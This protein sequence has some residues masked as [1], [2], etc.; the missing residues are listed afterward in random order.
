ML[1]V[2]WTTE[3]APRL[4]ALF[5]GQP[6][7]PIRLWA[8]LDG[9]I[10][11]R[12]LV[13]QPEQPTLALV[14]E[15]AEATT[16]IGGAATPKAVADAFTLLRQHQEVVVCLWP[17]DPMGAVLPPAP[18]YEGMA[19]DFTDRSPAVDISQLAA[20]PSGYHFRRIDEEIAPS[21][22][23]F[24]YY[25]SMFGGVEQAI[26]NTVGYCL[27]QGEQVVSEA[28]AGPLTRGMAE[29]GVGTGEPY[30]RQGFATATAARVI[31]A[32]EE[33]GYAPFWNASEQNAPSVALAK[34]L[35]FQTEQPFKVLAWSALTGP[36]VQQQL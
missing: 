17:D 5:I 11:G 7:V 21:L 19:I 12:I 24:D 34:R 36:A 18:Y 9:T 8:I 33:R 32:C 35:G 25:V 22:E 31:Q 3:I 23:G 27:M 2:P 14:Q 30:R 6:P 4:K 10:Q 29:I 15:L 13:D 26:Q 1:I 20:P 16:Y 28:V